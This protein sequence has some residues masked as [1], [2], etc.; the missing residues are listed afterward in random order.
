MD[1]ADLLRLL[2]I[3]PADLDPA[4]PW[5]PYRG[6][7]AERI[8]G[9]RPC[10]GCGEPA[11]STRLVDVPGAG[12]RWLDTCRDHMLA[13]AR[14]RPS[15]MPPTVERIAADLHTAARKAAVDLTVVTD[16]GVAG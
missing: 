3:D 6:T 15:R 10:A 16:D 4:P 14:L 2:D 9:S 5:A 7:G 12:R 13:A 1:D 11:R 8:D